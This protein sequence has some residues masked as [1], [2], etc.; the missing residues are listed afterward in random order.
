M[1]SFF[2]DFDAMRQRNHGFVDVDNGYVWSTEWISMD[3]L[4]GFFPDISRE[5]NPVLESFVQKS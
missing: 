5:D 1:F 2:C 4:K 3:H